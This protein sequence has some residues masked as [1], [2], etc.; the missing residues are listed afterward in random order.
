ME[1]I[2][3]CNQFSNPQN[4]WLYLHIVVVVAVAGVVFVW[5]NLL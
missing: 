1:Y 5:H 3:V 2:I 4:F